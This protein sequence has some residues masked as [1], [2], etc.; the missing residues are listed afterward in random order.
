MAPA[1]RHRGVRVRHEVASPRGAPGGD[2]ALGIEGVLEG[3]RQAV[4]RP[5]LG[6]AGERP[7]GRR[8]LLERALRGQLDHSVERRIDRLDAGEMGRHSLDRRD[9]F[10]LDG[11]RQSGR[12]AEQE[13]VHLSPA[14]SR[15]GHPAVAF[16]MAV[17]RGRR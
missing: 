15:T 8:G 7:V 13:V 5:E 16:S 17:F 14:R 3:D 6:A 12:G 1:R 10:C 2:D 11:S 9:L 4:Q